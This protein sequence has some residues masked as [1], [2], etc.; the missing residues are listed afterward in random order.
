MPALPGTRQVGMITAELD[1]IDETM[2]SAFVALCL[3]INS[4][5]VCKAPKSCK[6]NRRNMGQPNPNSLQYCPIITQSAFSLLGEQQP[7]KSRR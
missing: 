2:T 4:G 1:Y 5:K 3:S 7:S 6:L